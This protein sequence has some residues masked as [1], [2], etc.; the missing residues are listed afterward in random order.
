MKVRLLEMWSGL[1]NCQAKYLNS[2]CLGSLSPQL[3]CTSGD[4]TASC[5]PAQSF[6]LGH[7]PHYR[8]RTPTHT[9]PHPPTPA[10]HAAGSDLDH[11]VLEGRRQEGVQEGQL[12]MFV[13]WRDRPCLVQP[14]SCPPYCNAMSNSK[15]IARRSRV[16]RP[17]KLQLNLTGDSSIAITPVG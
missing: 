17:R 9:F 2:S 14:P 16:S 4:C 13:K 7:L 5:P 10:A 6:A 12:R 1:R 11:Q 15:I 3:C 8:P